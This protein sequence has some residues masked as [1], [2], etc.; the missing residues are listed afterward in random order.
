MKKTNC[1][2]LIYVARAWWQHWQSNST[3][4]QDRDILHS[5]KLLL[6][7]AVVVLNREKKLTASKSIQ[8]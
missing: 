2:F 4:V 1:M 3:P 6:L 7:N 8:N 5:K